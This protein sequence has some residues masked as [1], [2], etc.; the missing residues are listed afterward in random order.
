MVQ[1]Y[2]VCRNLPRKIEISLFSN[3]SVTIDI[4]TEYKWEC[5]YVT[6]HHSVFLGSEPLSLV[7]A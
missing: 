7:P 2:N 5:D 3:F 6:R 4:H 1:E